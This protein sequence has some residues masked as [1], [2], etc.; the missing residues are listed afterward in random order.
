MSLNLPFLIYLFVSIESLLICYSYWNNIGILSIGI[1]SAYF[2]PAIA[3]FRLKNSQYSKI[4]SFLVVGVSILISIPRGIL[5]IHDT[6]EAGRNIARAELDSYPIPEKKVINPYVSDC[7]KFPSWEALKLQECNNKNILEN[8]K[9]NEAEEEYKKE[10]R[11]YKSYRYKRESEIKESSLV[12]LNLKNFA[13]ILLFLVSMPI[14]PII[15]IILIKAEKEESEKILKNNYEK[16]I[17]NNFEKITKSNTNNR[18]Q[19]KTGKAGRKV[20]PDKKQ[21]AE[22]LLRTGVNYKEVAEELEISISSLYRWKK[23]F[24]LDL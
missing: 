22:V 18:N 16:I 4:I 5:M 1:S 9:F 6:I 23:D 20:D 17:R 2:L 19:Q 7:S 3:E 24:S 13:I 8:Q 15:N 21:K 14:L 12:Y 11:E 10:M